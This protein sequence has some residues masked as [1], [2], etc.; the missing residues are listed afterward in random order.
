MALIEGVMVVSLLERAYK[1]LIAEWRS[2]GGWEIIVSAPS[3]VVATLG[4]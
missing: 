3:F 4:A 2:C 1:T